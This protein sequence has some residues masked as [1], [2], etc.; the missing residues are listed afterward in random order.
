M[1]IRLSSQ[2]VRNTYTLIKRI[3]IRVKIAKVLSNKDHQ[4]EGWAGID[5][6]YHLTEEKMAKVV[7]MIPCCEQQDTEERTPLGAFTTSLPTWPLVNFP[8]S[9]SACFF[10]SLHGNRC[11]SSATSPWNKE[12]IVHVRLPQLSLCNKYHLWNWKPEAPMQFS[13]LVCYTNT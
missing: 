6:K 3:L 7:N 11:M 2:L 9:L 13:S 1:C 12:N 4:E 8:F 5:E 10:L